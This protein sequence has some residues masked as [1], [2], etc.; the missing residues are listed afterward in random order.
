MD[1]WK[2]MLVKQQKAQIIRIMRPAEIHALIEASKVTDEPNWTK[3]RNEPTLKDIGIT[4]HDLKIWMKF[5]LYSGTRFSEAMI[6][7]DYRDPDGKTLYQDNGTLW[8]PRYKGKQKRTFQTRTIYF[9]YKGREILNAFFE[10]PSLP[11]STKEE[12]KQTLTSISEIMHTAG[13]RINLPEKTLNATFEK[14]IKDKSGNPVKEMY[15][16]NNFT[17][18]PDGT[19]SKVMKERIV[20]E[21]YEKPFTTNGCAFRTFR[22]TWESWLTSSFDSPLMRDKVLSSQ[23]HKK[24]IALNHYVE[25]SFDKEDSE[26]IKKEVLGYAVLE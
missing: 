8:M 6:I 1:K 10:T 20:K 16:T 2:Y 15:E 12:V 11:H 5:F 4:D 24:E 7:H 18:N 23:G 14:T 25:I 17:Q 26:D 19:Y 3:S 22:K 21:I 9:S 13:K